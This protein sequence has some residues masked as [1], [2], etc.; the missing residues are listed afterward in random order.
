MINIPDPVLEVF[1]LLNKCG[2]QAYLVGGCV[3]DYLLGK[4]PE[5]F[6]MTT[7]ATPDEM[8]ECFKNERFL[9]TGLKHGTLTVIKDGVAVEV[10]THRTE[11][12]YSDSRHPD[13]VTFSKNI[14]EDLKRRD[15]TINALA[16][17]LEKGIIDCFDGVGDINRQ[18]VKSVGDP[19]R[20]FAEDGL[21]ILRGLRFS[22]VLGFPIENQTFSAMQKQ[23]YRLERISAER[24]YQ[25]LDKLLLADYVREAII[26]G[27]QIIGVVIPEILPLIS[28]EQKNPHHCY[29]LLT[30]T[31]VSVEAAPMVSEIR[32]AM[33]FHDLG[34]PQCASLDDKGIGHYYGHSKVSEEIAKRRLNALRLP[35]EK[36]KKICQL[37]KY[38]D[39][40]IE[41]DERLLKRWLNR[42]GEESFR[43]LLEIKRADCRA[44][45]ECCR[46]RLEEYDEIEGIIEKLIAEQACFSIKDLAVDGNDLI[47]AGIQ[48]GPEIG[49]VLKKLLT[50][51]IEERVANEKE[52]LLRFVEEGEEDVY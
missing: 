48:K 26:K 35:K 15:F 8:K 3:R 43:Q 21:R 49:K 2:F 42:L 20:R 50:A 18:L 6:D 31:A 37:I 27:A 33:L 12:T 19:E 41:K 51:V 45:A 30:H 4:I 14:C 25:E 40:V 28:Y 7:D 16:Y 34:K 10:T 52:A 9:E 23:A 11:G 47:H 46:Y 44:Q 1:S 38:H 32:W 22:A 24:I 36:I 17:H 5:D 13:A 29:D 39:S